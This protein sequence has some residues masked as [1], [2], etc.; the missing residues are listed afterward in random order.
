MAMTYTWVAPHW[1]TPPIP[2]FKTMTAYWQLL[3]QEDNLTARIEGNTVVPYDPKTAKILFQDMTDEQR[4]ALLVESMP[5]E[6][7]DSTL[8]EV[9]AR[10]ESI[11]KLMEPHRGPDGFPVIPTGP[12]ILPSSQLAP[13]A[14]PPPAAAE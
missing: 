14:P 13:P 7:K 9:T 12:E 1:T 6:Q 4:I 5:S 10:L 8:K 3:A 2:D 11:T